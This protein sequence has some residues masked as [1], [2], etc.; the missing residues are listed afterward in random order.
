MF[1]RSIIIR[2]LHKGI[3]NLS[4][5]KANPGIG[6]QLELDV[7]QHLTDDP[8]DFENMES[9]FYEV[10][11]TH[12]QHEEE[13]KQ[14]REHV[15]H[16]MVKHKYF[17]EQKLPNLLTYAEKEQIRLLHTRDPEEWSVE[18]LT[19]SFPA[20]EDI[21]KKILSA[22]WRPRSTKR[23]REHD[24][25]VIRNWEQLRA[26]KE[27]MQ[28][29]PAELR[30]HL[31]KFVNRKPADLIDTYDNIPTRLEIP[32]PK[33]NEFVSIITT[34][35]K[36]AEKE[37]EPPVPQLN[38]PKENKFKNFNELQKEAEDETYL[39][40]TVKDKR[41]MRI[42]ELKQK[43]LSPYE[44]SQAMENENTELE[45]KAAEYLD[46]TSGTGILPHNTPSSAVTGT[47]ESST[48]DFNYVQKFESSEIVVSPED[49]QRFEMFTIK[50]RIYIPRKL[51]RK[52]ATFKVEDCY[53]DDDGEFLYRVPGMTGQ[54]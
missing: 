35:H 18:R 33:G 17:R 41:Y 43:K 10:H 52:G 32:K 29:L 3:T 15:R 34:C 5:R 21:I 42:H 49:R 38:A 13:M 27:E 37:P 48:S 28:K 47:S 4:R 12:R 9:D 39:M 51:W 1:S 8:E 53:Y 14:Q 31:K 30:E 11:K 2:T 6:H 16:L 36:Y 22:K 26:N 45:K 44:L 23:I 19:E 40:D 50:E 25:A 46:N 20:T 54:K 24:E 7:D